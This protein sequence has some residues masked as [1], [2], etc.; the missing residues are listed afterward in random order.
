MIDCCGL[1]C[2]DDFCQKVRDGWVVMSV[3]KASNIFISHLV[4]LSANDSSRSIDRCHQGRIPRK[5]H[6]NFSKQSDKHMAI[7]WPDAAKTLLVAVWRSVRTFRRS[8]TQLIDLA[9]RLLQTDLII[10]LSLYE[11]PHRD[12][13]ATLGSLATG[14]RPELRSGKNATVKAWLLPL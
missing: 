11:A 12:S 9:V 3:P 2:L 4:K 6:S 7:Y 14:L 1:V 5:I 10:T 13:S 8:L